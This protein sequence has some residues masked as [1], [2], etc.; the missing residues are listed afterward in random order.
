[1]R[2]NRGY[3]Q[4]NAAAELGISITAW[5]KIERGQTNLSFNRMMQIAELF[6]TDITSLL[7]SVSDDTST[8]ETSSQNTGLQAREEI[9]AYITGPEHETCRREIAHLKELLRAKEVIIELLRKT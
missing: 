5:S 9:P 8:M 3:S 1:M 7:S 4:E 2:Q 6:S